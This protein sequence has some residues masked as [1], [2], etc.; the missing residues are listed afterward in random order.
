MSGAELLDRLENTK[1][2]TKKP[3]SQSVMG[4]AVLMTTG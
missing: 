4:P 2:A 1:S 3:G